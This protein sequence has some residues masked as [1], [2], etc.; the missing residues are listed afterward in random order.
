M[1]ELHTTAF[2]HK[3]ALGQMVCMNPT[4]P[5]RFADGKIIAVMTDLA[6]A[7]LYTV[8][9][10]DNSRNCIARHTVNEYE[11]HPIVKREELKAEKP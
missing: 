3:Y 9:V 8:A 10:F 1:T 4:G 5:S 11:I 6:G 2:K 7:I